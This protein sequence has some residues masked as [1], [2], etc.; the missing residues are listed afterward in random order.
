MQTRPRS[1]VRHLYQGISWLKAIKPLWAVL[2]AVYYGLGKSTDVVLDLED[3][4][5][6]L[7]NPK[8]R[9]IGQRVYLS[10]SYGTA[11]T[12]LIRHLICE[13]DIVVDVGA[14]IGYFTPQDSPIAENTLVY[15]LAHDSREAAKASWAAFVADPEWQ[16]VYEESKRDGD[17][18]EKLESVFLDATD[19]SMMK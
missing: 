14:N 17:I 12:K 16:Q 4:H 2:R 1:T 10:G 3:G 9:G 5:R 11:R 13:G 8:D 19:Y 7:V 15:L 18:V 6:F